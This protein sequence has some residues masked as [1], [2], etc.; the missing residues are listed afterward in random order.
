MQVFHACRFTHSISTEE[1]LKGHSSMCYPGLTLAGRIVFIFFLCELCLL[2]LLK[3]KSSNYPI[4]AYKDSVENQD[5]QSLLRHFSPET[6]ERQTPVK[7]SHSFKAQESGYTGFLPGR[8]QEGQG[9]WGLA[10]QKAVLN[11]H[12]GFYP[13]LFHWYL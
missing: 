8:P 7:T 11:P 5:P 12:H 2:T 1:T 3:R 9:L 6:R 4:K 13:L 10:I